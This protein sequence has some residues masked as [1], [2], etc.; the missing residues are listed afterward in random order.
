M[1]VIP[2]IRGVPLN[3]EQRTL[4][5]DCRKK[6]GMTQKELGEKIGRKA[7]T[8]HTIE[9]GKYLPSPSVLEELCKTLSLD[10]R[11]VIEVHLCNAKNA[12]VSQTRATI[13]KHGRG[14]RVGKGHE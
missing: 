9:A 8:I 5:I 3:E 7:I 12:A 2:G 1:D 4:L 13:S 11:V 10:C 14:K 6:L